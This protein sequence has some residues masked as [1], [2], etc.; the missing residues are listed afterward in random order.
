MGTRCGRS[1]ATAAP[2]PA[3]ATYVNLY[4]WP[5]S[6]AEFVKSVGNGGGAPPRRA[7][8]R[9]QP[10]VV[11]GYSCRQMYLRSYTFS[12]RET[13]PERARKR[14]V[15]MKERVAGAAVSA[16]CGFAAAVRR[17]RRSAPRSSPLP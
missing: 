5:E 12:K 6:D 8:L 1:P 10:P 3:R 11:D 7:A 4:R 16:T 14:L 15:K 9:H 13:L 2:P 17:R